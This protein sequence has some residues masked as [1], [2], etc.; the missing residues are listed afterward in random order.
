MELIELN[1]DKNRVPV[2]LT[3]MNPSAGNFRFQHSLWGKMERGE[4]KVFY[5]L[6]NKTDIKGFH[7]NI[8]L[9]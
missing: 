3:Q 8:F 5:F 6:A 1:K 4:R 2:L 9:Y 7:C